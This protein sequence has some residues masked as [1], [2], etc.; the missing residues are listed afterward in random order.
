MRSSNAFVTRWIKSRLFDFRADM[1]ADEIRSRLNAEKTRKTA[2]QAELA[3]LERLVTLN[4]FDA[5]LKHQLQAQA[6]AVSALLNKHTPQARQMLRK[7]LVGPIELEPVG[8][9]RLRGYKFRGALTVERLISG[10]AGALKENTSV[11]G[12]PNGFR[13]P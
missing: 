10:Q 2:L 5:N 1:P 6:G 12:G 9:G 8:S 13:P 11:Y 7:L 3:K 4:H